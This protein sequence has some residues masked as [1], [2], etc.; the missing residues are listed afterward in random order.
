MDKVKNPRGDG[1]SILEG[2]GVKFTNQRGLPPS[3]PPQLK[4]NSPVALVIFDS[5]FLLYIPVYERY[6]KPA[7]G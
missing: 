4:K 6:S 1:V 2:G 3:P 7:V 5:T